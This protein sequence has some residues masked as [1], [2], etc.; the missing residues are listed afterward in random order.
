M[1]ASGNFVPPTFIFPRKKMKADLLDGAPPSSV[2]MVS[3]SGFINSELFPDWLQHFQDNAQVVRKTLACYYWT[4]THHIFLSLKSI[5]AGNIESI[6]YSY[7]LTVAT[8]PSSL[9]DLS[10]DI[11]RISCECDKWMINQPDRPIT[12]YQVASIFTK[13]Y[14][15]AATIVNAMKCVEVIAVC[16]FNQDIFSELHFL[17]P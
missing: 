1:S 12:V 4:I 11:S 7:H 9:T 17:L 3:E 6:C 2:G 16:P 14:V 13:A 15:K 5:S 10:L 8:K